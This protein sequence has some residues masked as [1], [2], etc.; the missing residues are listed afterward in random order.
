LEC[1]GWFRYSIG[2][3]CLGAGVP[4]HQYHCRRLESCLE[5]CLEY[6][7]LGV[8]LLLLLLLLLIVRPSL[9]SDS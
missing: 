5:S 6:S 2:S 9:V 4:S 8:A 7:A 3:L 1:V